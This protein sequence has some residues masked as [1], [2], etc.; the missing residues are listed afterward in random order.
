MSTATEGARV[1]RCVR[2]GLV[3]QCGLV[4]EG[5]LP[6]GRDTGLRCACGSRRLRSLRGDEL[7][8]W[9]ALEGE[10][11]LTPQERC[12]AVMV[13]CGMQGRRP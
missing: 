10:G 1:L 6:A 12:R 8:A 5:N 13:R 4:V 9:A 7:R 3:V 11:A 2:C